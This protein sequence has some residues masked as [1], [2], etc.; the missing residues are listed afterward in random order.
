MEHLDLVRELKLI[1]KNNCPKFKKGDSYKPAKAVL[2]QKYAPNGAAYDVMISW[3]QKSIRR[4]LV[5]QAMYCA[6]Q[7]ANMRGI[8]FS[9]LLNRLIIIL[10]EDIGFAEQGLC[11]LAVDTYINCWRR[12]RETGDDLGDE[13][14]AAILKLV[15][16]LASASHSRY[17]DE[18]IHWWEHGNVTISDNSIANFRKL[19]TVGKF[20][21]AAAVALNIA[22]A[23]RRESCKVAGKRK[24]LEIFKC[25]SILLETK[26]PD[27]YPLFRLYELR[28]DDLQLVHA[29]GIVAMRRELPTFEK[30]IV[31]GVR[32][33]WDELL[34]L[35]IPILNAAIDKH[36]MIGRNILGRGSVYF[37]TEGVKLAKEIDFGRSKEFRDVFIA[38][39]RERE[40]YNRYKVL[41]ARPYQETIV[42]Q[43]IAASKR[44]L[45]LRDF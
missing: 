39:A 32:K 7:I 40:G 2:F 13:N 3:L 29:V 19:L 34:T 43:T 17:V 35:K 27:I 22:T 41:T 1:D 11:K 6:V 8:F 23:A 30:Y 25:W 4:N 10:S 45:D 20:V 15:K 14:K 38:E 36:T 37:W 5:V 9:H 44:N 28:K 26:H 31:K 21:D 12:R 33:T 16:N 42:K 24:Q 18:V